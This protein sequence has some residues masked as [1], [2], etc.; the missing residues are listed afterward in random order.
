M[1]LFIIGDSGENKKSITVIIDLIKLKKNNNSVLILAGDNFYP[2]GISNN[3]DPKIDEFRKSFSGL[4]IPI[5]GV[6][7]NHDYVLNPKAQINL[8]INDVDWRMPG[9]YYKK[10]FEDIDVFFIDTMLIR[11]G[12]NGENVYINFIDKVPDMWGESL[13][14][15][16][17]KQLLWLD[18][19][20]EKSS[21]KWKAVVG[22]YPI[23]SDGY[24]KD[25]NELKNVLYPILEKHNV[26]FYFC[27][28]D[29][30]LQ[31]HKIGSLL[32]VVNGIAHYTYNRKGNKATVFCN[33]G[34]VVQ[35]SVNKKK[36]T[37]NAFTNKNKLI[38]TIDKLK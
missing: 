4:N 26:D 7:G 1:D 16:K 33:E 22:H 37:L 9:N 10:S 3:K 5:Y 19:E 31:V 11:P 36:C 18:Q 30:N 8:K 28:H 27:G 20:L 23:Q 12:Y 35:L 13:E 34:G 14:K 29:H 24:Y 2:D 25:W 21:N 38:Y 17:S 15:L 32:Q 6:L